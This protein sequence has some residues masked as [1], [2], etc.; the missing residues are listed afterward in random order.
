M[1]RVTVVFKSAERGVAQDALRALGVP[2]S[3]AT[4]F[5]FGAVLSYTKDFVELASG[6]DVVVVPT[7][8][9]LFIRRSRPT[10]GEVE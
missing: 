2:G 7:R 6:D 8:N 3:A 1:S 9:V 5:N 10:S 4:G